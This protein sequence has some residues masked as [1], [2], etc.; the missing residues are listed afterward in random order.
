MKRRNIGVVLAVIAAL[1]VAVFFIPYKRVGLFAPYGSVVLAMLAIGA[2]L[3]TLATV[4][5]R[6][7]P[8]NRRAEYKAALVLGVLTIVGNLCTQLSIQ[9]ISPGLLSVVQQTQILMVTAAAFCFLGER[10]AVGF[11]LGLILALVGLGIIRFPGADTAHANLAGVVFALVSSL[12]FALMHVYTR[13]VIHEIR[14]ATVNA[15]RLWL[16]VL[17]LALVPGFASGLNSLGWYGWLLCG[18]AALLGPF[19]GRVLVMHA[20]RYIPAAE[21]SLYTLITPVFAYFLGFLFYDIVPVWQEYLGSTILIVGV[22][23]PLLDQWRNK[24]RLGHV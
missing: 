23:L 2:A 22:F 16:A 13:K 17:V 8:S 14:P 6:G 20:V 5:E 10:P 3:S 18:L 12:G 21:S 19:L 11:W 1:F 9:L 15:A 7:R 4:T 24:D